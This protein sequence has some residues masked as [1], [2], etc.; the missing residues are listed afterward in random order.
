VL[1][2]SRSKTEVKASEARGSQCRSTGYTAQRYYRG[3]G[4]WLTMPRN[5]PTNVL[6]GGTRQRNIPPVR[7]DG[8]V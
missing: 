4:D 5:E 7:G 2:V 8:Y 1:V 6:P 3:T